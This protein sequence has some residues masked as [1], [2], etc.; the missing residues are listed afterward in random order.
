MK[1]TVVTN[2]ENYKSARNL[3]TKYIIFHEKFD[4]LDRKMDFYLTTRAS[5]FKSTGYILYAVNV[6]P[7]VYK[8]KAWVIIPCSEYAKLIFNPSRLKHDK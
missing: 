1:R 4:N 2:K 5:T 7:Y 3:K 6:N 8:A